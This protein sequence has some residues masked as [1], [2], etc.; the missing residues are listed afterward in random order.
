MVTGYG[1]S[2]SYDQVTEYTEAGWLEDLPRLLTGRYY[3]A[4]GHFVNEDHQLAAQ[5]QEPAVELLRSCAMC[6]RCTW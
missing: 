3:H 4:C 1:G 6:H 5:S 2:Y